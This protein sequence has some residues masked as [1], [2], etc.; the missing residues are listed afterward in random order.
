MEVKTSVP[1]DITE[2]IEGLIVLFVA[3]PPLI[4]A[5]YRLRQ[6]QGGGLESVTK[7]WN[8]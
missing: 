1:I 2:V 3:T 4:R 7:G 5:L 8:G 6:T